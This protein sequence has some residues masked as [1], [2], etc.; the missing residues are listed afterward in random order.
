MKRQQIS[1]LLAAHYSREFSGQVHAGYDTAK[2]KYRVYGPA[3]PTNNWACPYWTLH[4]YLT[5]TEARA[6]IRTIRK[7]ES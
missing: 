4:Q 3:L 2:R 6:K 5:P 7:K 1:D